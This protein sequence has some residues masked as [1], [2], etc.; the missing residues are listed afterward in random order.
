M[1]KRKWGLSPIKYI[2]VKVF[3]ILISSLNSDNFSEPF[4]NQNAFTFLKLHHIAF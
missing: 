2:L 3:S 4:T 1:I